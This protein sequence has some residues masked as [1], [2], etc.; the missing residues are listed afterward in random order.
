MATV[1]GACSVPSLLCPARL[2][3]LPLAPHSRAPEPVSSVLAVSS[4]M[5]AH[6]PLISVA[7]C[8]RDLTPM[9]C[10]PWRSDRTIGSRGGPWHA[11][12]VSR[13]LW[14]Q[15]G[16]RGGGGLVNEGAFLGADCPSLPGRGPPAP[17]GS[18]RVLGWPSSA[19]E[20]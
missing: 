1:P 15:A 12:R 9:A 16:R 2:S 8:R 7:L 6:P 19:Q 10:L 4:A 17:G 13:R 11:S 5:G 20:C 14:A 3:F 18:S